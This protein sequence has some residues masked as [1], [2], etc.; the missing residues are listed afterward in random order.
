MFL[1]ALSVIAVMECRVLSIQS[2]VVRGYVGNKSATFP[3]Q[4]R[5]GSIKPLSSGNKTEKNSTKTGKE[6]DMEMPLVQSLT[7]SCVR[8]VT[9]ILTLYQGRVL[10][11]RNI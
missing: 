1:K 9:F 8:R 4:V 7:S 11:W 6:I 10:T 2:H 3:L 5:S